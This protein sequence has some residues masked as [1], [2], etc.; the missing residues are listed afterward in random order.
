MP[1]HNAFDIIIV[2]CG[3]AGLSAAV[4]YAEA[5][6]AEGRKPRIAVLECAPKEERGGATRWTSALS[7]VMVAATSVVR[8]FRFISRNGRCANAV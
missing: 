5:A 7:A 2:G 6:K 8:M 4:S 1:Q 3:A